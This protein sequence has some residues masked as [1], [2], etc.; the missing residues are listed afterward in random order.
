L[1]PDYIDFGQRGRPLPPTLQTSR[2]D[3]HSPVDLRRTDVT[4]AKHR[5]W[6][7]WP[8]VYRLHPAPRWSWGEVSAPAIISPL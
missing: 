6:F 4:S 5:L 7:S 3:D 2:S 1:I 8:P